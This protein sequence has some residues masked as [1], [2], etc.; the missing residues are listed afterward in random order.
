MTASLKATVTVSTTGGFAPPKA[1]CDARN[2]RAG[3]KLVVEAPG[4]SV[5]LRPE[6][7]F[8]LTNIDDVFGSLVHHGKRLTGEDVETRLNAAM[9]KRIKNKDS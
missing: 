2:W 3:Q 6:R 8:A 9:R 5:L 7:R 1:I 4:V